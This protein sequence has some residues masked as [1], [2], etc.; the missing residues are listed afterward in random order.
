[1]LVHRFL[2][3][4]DS[5][6]LNVLGASMD[7]FGL[8]WQEREWDVVDADPKFVCRNVIENCDFPLCFAVLQL[9]RKYALLRKFFPIQIV[10]ITMNETE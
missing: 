7:D 5:A 1:M 2:V 3:Q 9:E 8:V 6:T 10:Q 4:L